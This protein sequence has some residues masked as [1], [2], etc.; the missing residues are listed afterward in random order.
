MAEE[1][2]NAKPKRLP[3]LAEPDL[4]TPEEVAELR[5]KAKENSAFYRMIFD[6]LLTRRSPTR[7]VKPRR[8]E[9][10]HKRLL[11]TFGRRLRRTNGG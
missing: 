1:K 5:R 3:A 9:R 2:P 10:T 4:L 8:R 6:P 11:P 7:A